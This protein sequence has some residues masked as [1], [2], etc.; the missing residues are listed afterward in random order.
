MSSRVVFRSALWGALVFA[1]FAVL[2]QMGAEQSFSASAAPS[3][4]EGAAAT[5]SAQDTGPYEDGMRAITD[6]RWLDAEAIFTKVAAQ[7]GEHS[8]GALYWK[9]YAQN[10]QGQG[11][12]ALGT[13]AELRRDFSTSN[14]VHECGALEIEIQANAGKPVEPKVWSDDDLKLLALASLMQKDE[15]RAL[16]QLQE[17]LNGDSSEELKKKAMFILGQHYSDAT[18]AQIVRVS[19]VEGDVRIAR[20]EQN[21]KPAGEAWEQAVADLPLETGFSLVT[22]NGRAEIELEDASTIYLGENSV[23][24]FNDLHTTSGVPYTEVALLS[25]TISLAVKPYIYGE[26]FVLRTP[27]DYI[28]VT[29]PHRALARISSYIDA[30]TV[31]SQESESLH[32]LQLGGKELAKGQMLTLREGRLIGTGPDDSGAH[33]EW[34][35]WVADRIAQ[36]TEAMADVMKDAGLAS[37][38]PG[39][40]SMKGQGT[41]FDCAP[42]GRCWEPATA[43]D[44]Q[45]PG[46]KLSRTRPPS[47]AGWGEPAHVMQASFVNSLRFQAAQLM[48]MGSPTPF[49]PSYWG[50][51]SPCFPS[52]VRYQVQK[53]PITGKARV[54]N[55]GLGGNAVP[56]GWAVCHAGGWIYRRHHYVWCVGVKR[57]H[58]EP[59]RWV[60]SE[61]KVGFVPIHPFDVKGRPPINRKEEVFAVNNKKG[62]SL[63]RVKFEPNHTI[64]VLKS[65]PREFRNAY[66]HPLARA[67]APRMEA[68]A[69]KEPLPWNKG[70][71][72][73][74]VNVPIRFDSKSQTFM[75]SKEVMHGGKSVTVST[76]ISNHAGTL[77]AR[78]GSFA[79][80]HGGF[81]GG[82]SAH[83]GGGSG[84]SG[85]GSHGG[86]SSGSS[87]GGSHG[88]GSSGSASSSGGSSAGGGGGGG[89]GHR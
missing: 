84:G 31:T 74:G 4:M 82:N 12:A 25:G 72:T 70:T 83:A 81:S 34:D 65:P 3:G 20:G 26:T 32:F 5:Y 57:H 24:T 54:V 36:R 50:A 76:P 44:G 62:L 48:P 47:A 43:E 19:Y 58:L 80:G 27:T 60:K 21:E 40:A 38:L 61:H 9:A 37:P 16:A 85:G 17:I 28:A 39:L 53:D 51:F 89:G 75:M 88:G 35:K 79:G 69:M 41:F 13:C 18:Y 33:A 71:I 46:D 23:L 64:D 15:P 56:W 11:N 30:T 77:Q 63:E 6:G 52:A 10:K 86:G 8:D 45:Q 59:V 7:H 2:A 73:K 87:G 42:Y 66:L 55:S 49:D 67:D 29:H 14:W 1:P 78:G 22:G 68:H